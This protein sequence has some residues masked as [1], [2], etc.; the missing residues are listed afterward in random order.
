L[1]AR[2]HYDPTTGTMIKYTFHNSFS[3]SDKGGA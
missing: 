3:M 1:R 2:V